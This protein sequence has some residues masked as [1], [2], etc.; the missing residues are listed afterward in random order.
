MVFPSITDGM[1]Y[2]L[3]SRDLIADSERK[4]F[5]VAQYYIFGDCI[6]GDKISGVLL[7]PWDGHA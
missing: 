2:S 3:V 4:P 6:A 1:R 5:G 7:L